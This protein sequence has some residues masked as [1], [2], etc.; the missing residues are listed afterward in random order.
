MAKRKFPGCYEI[1]VKAEDKEGEIHVDYRFRL[2][3][4]SV[5]LNQELGIIKEEFLAQEYTE[6]ELN[7]RHVDSYWPF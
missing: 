7:A 6:I 1:R 5:E 2:V 4:D 3:K